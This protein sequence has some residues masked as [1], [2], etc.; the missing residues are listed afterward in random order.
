MQQSKPILWTKDFII[1]SAMN[2]FFTLIFFLLMVTIAVYAVDEFQA[3]TSEAGLVSGIFIIG[4]L[5]GRLGAGRFIEQV[6]TKRLLL[7]G[8]ICFGITT[9]LYFGI[10]SLS[11]LLVNRLLHGV[12]FGI[13]STATGTIVA[14]IIPNSRRGEGVGFYSLSVSLATAIGPFVGMYLRVNANFPTIFAICFGLVLISFFTSFFLRAPQVSLTKEQMKEMSGFKFS[15]F[16]EPRAIPIA[17]VIM[18]TGFCYSSVLSFLTFYTMEINLVQSASFFFLV[19]AIVVLF[20]RPFTGKWLDT[21]GPNIIVYP[22][23]TLFAI[24]MFILSQAHHGI[25]LLL[26]GAIIGLGF[27]NFQSSAQALA[28][29]LAPPHRV[30]LATSTFFIFM[31]IGF[32]IGP[33]ILGFLIPITGYRGLYAAMGIIVAFTII[34]YYFLYGKKAHETK[35]DVSA[36][37]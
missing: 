20:S 4:V 11:F 29:K 3:S 5:L 2:F 35:P 33:Y 22:T 27:G 36:H 32:G 18:L 34:L 6:G 21:K 13:V 7:M 37:A 19:Y 26:A 12:S 9:L 31:D 14:Q 23:L 16:I 28:V 24:G 25:I 15:N 10:N 1:V 8:I 30:G 17:F